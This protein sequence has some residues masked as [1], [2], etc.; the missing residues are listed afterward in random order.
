[1]PMLEKSMLPRVFVLSVGDNI[2]CIG[3]LS[4]AD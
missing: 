3:E 1:L 4:C 2:V